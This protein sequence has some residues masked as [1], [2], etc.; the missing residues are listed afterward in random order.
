MSRS[1]SFFRSYFLFHVRT[2]FPRSVAALSNSEGKEIRPCMAGVRHHR[3]QSHSSSMCHQGCVSKH[4]LIK[5]STL[6]LADRP[7]HY[8]CE[9]WSLVTHHDAA[10]GTPIHQR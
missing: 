1:G 8:K 9:H 10:V 5:N 3:N 6:T 7:R 2:H 4:A